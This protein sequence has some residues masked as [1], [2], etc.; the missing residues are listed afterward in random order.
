MPQLRKAGAIAGAF[1]LLQCISACIIFPDKKQNC[2]TCPP[3]A[4]EFLART[5][6]AAIIHNMAESFHARD[7]NHYTEQLCAEYVFR[8]IPD[9][10]GHS[11][12]LIRNE[13]V[14]FAEHLFTT[15]STDGTQLAA[16]KISLAI[17]TLASNPDG[18]VGHEGW[19][20]YYVNTRLAISLPDGQEINVVS[21]AY[22]FFHQDNA[23]LWCLAEWQDETPTQ[24]PERFFSVWEGSQLQS[25]GSPYARSQQPWFAPGYSV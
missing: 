18:R 23:G 4:G 15:G 8:F 2:P 5:S 19:L 7:F 11:D 22:L 1:L 21:P 16:S 9:N 3:P 6:P 25:S 13:E 24:R 17:D 12:S 20:R 14:N 10:S